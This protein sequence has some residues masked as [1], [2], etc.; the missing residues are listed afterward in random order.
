[1]SYTV[2]T[3]CDIHHYENCPDCFGFGF[4]DDGTIMSAVE[5]CDR[6]YIGWTRC[7]TCGSSPFGVPEKAT[8]ESERRDMTRKEEI[9]MDNINKYTV[10]D[11]SGDVQ[12]VA[13]SSFFIAAGVSLVFIRGEEDKEEWVAAFAPG[14]WSAVSLLT[15]KE[16]EDN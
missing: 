4:H 15:D 14:H 8:K 11:Y 5:A 16:T 12:V 6:N 7:S 1:M 3:L 9:K 13:A 2:C 10:R